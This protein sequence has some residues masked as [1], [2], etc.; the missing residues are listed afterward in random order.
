MSTKLISKFEIIDHGIDHAQYFQG[1]GVSYT[2]YDECITG[3]GQDAKEAIEDALES[4]AQN[5][6]ETDEIEKSDE[7]KAIERAAN[8]MPGYEPLVTVS[9]FVE[10]QGE[11]MTDDCELYY[12][13]SIRYSVKE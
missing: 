5:G 2:E 12:Y 8:K 4:M 13:L 7:Y 3:C 10:K 11:E 1:C 6:V 9:A